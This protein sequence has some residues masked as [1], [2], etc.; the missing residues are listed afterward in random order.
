MLYV[1]RNMSHRISSV[2]RIFLCLRIIEPV[3]RI[4]NIAF[5]HYSYLDIGHQYRNLHRY[6]YFPRW[7]ATL[8]AAVEQIIEVENAKHICKV[9]HTFVFVPT[10]QLYFS[11][12]PH[13]LLALSE[14]Y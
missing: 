6:L 9:I 11:F 7:Y 13:V 2:Y 8:S 1:S 12:C 10:C 3:M 5:G 4:L 14:Q